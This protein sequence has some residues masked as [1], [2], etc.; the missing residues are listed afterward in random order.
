VDRVPGGTQVEIGV[1]I[2]DVGHFLKVGSIADKEAQRRTTSIYLINRVLPMLPHALCNHLCS[3]NP[4]EPKVSF[5]AFFRIDI[6]TGD[7]VRDPKPWFK[8]TVMSSV[9]RLNYDEVQECL[10]GHEIEPPSVYGGYTWPEIKSDIFLLEE[11][12]GKV[13]NGRL[14]G[15]ALSITKAKMVFHTR[16]SE[17]GVPTGYHLEEHCASHWIIEELMLMANRCVAEHLAGEHLAASSVL[18]N[19]KAPD[20]K[21]AEALGVLMRQNLGLEWDGSNAGTIYNCCRK[22]YAKYGEVMGLCVEMM[23][24]RCGMQQ[25]EYFV[26]GT[27]KDAEDPH[28]FALNFDFYT[29]FTSPIRRYP[30]VMVHR[31]LGALLGLEDEYQEGETACTQVETCNEKRTASRKCQE[32]LDRSVFCIYL[33]ARKEWFYTVGT[34]LSLKEDTKKGQDMITIYS[35]QLG[36]EKK[37]LLCTAAEAK[38]LELYEDL[39]EDDELLLP[40]SW[41]FAGK[42]ACDLVWEDPSGKAKPFIQ[43]LKLFSCMPIVIIPTNTVP[44]DFAMFIVSPFH[45][46]FQRVTKDIPQI[47]QEGLDYKEDEVEDGVEVVHH[48]EKPGL[49]FMG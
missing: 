26:C 28:H 10:D 25:A 11:V 41:K 46:K 35:S 18:R 43:K 9:C 44:I 17:D 21:K 5:S 14:S 7:L 8:K 23:V 38:R 22:I 33:R 24:M 27:G 16:E 47:S 15:G 37:V 31:V 39:N 48:A 19:H 45:K 20:E 42:G 13:R 40:K 6:A 34:V 32:Q 49:A 2:A 1:H 36:K 4:N 3:L 29:H 12:C 30:D